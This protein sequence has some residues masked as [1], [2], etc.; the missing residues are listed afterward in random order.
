MEREKV[1]FVR[2]GLFC[3]GFPSERIFVIRFA[4]NA[5]LRGVAPAQY[6]YTSDRKPLTE[7]PPARG[8]DGLVVGIEIGRTP[9]GAFRVYMPDAEIYE[10]DDSHI[11]PTHAEESGRVPV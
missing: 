4:D 11:V 7:E 10:V 5:E 8:M 1:V 6:C 9:E 3:G 2:C